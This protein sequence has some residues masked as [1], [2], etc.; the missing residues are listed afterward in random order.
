MARER[1]IFKAFIAWYTEKH[2][3][4]SSLSKILQCTKNWDTLYIIGLGGSI[5]FFHLYLPGYFKH[6]TRMLL[7]LFFIVKKKAAYIRQ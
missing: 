4:F 2:S 6:K 7:L 5:L 3:T 1:W